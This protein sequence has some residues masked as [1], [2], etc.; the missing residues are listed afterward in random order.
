VASDSEQV[1][2]LSAEGLL[3]GAEPNWRLTMRRPVFAALLTANRTSVRVLVATT[4]LLLASSARAQSVIKTPGDHPLYS[5]E[6]EP[7]ALFGW[8]ANYAG[9]GFG[10]GGRV[11]IPLT[12]RGFIPS[13]NN[14][15]AISF[16][17]DWVHYSD[18][19]FYFKGTA[20]GCGADFFEFPI[21]MQWN[22]YVAS[23]WS[24]F[25]EPGLYIYHGSFDD[26][27][28]GGQGQPACGYPTATSVD[29]AFWVGARYHFTNKVALTMR[30]GFPT[31]SVGVSFMP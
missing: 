21:V 14:S 5:V 6:I 7:H 28:C 3:P 23:R 12:H 29:L 30:L 1:A 10:L 9:D 19:D 18:C 25:G 31:I 13:L 22:F 20:Y 17:L 24:V 8:D 15:V 16:G 4:A 26:N 11:S 27:Y 2:V